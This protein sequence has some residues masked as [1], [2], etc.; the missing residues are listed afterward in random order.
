MQEEPTKYRISMLAFDEP[1]RLWRAAHDLLVN[2]FGSD[3]F[4]LLGLY[5]TLEGL[6]TPP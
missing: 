3:Q 2:D 6:R 4:C 1:P 5:S